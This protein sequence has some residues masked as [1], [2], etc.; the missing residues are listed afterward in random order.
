MQQVEV[1]E[2]NLDDWNA[3]GFPHLCDQ[4]FKQGA[5]DVSLAPIQMKK[6]RPGYTLCV[7]SPIPIGSELRN[8]IFT[9]T[10]SIGLRY[11]KEF[12]HTLPRKIIEVST[13]WGKLRAKLVVTPDGER[14]YPEYDE[15]RQAAVNFGVPLMRVYNAVSKMSGEQ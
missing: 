13:P 9:E 6:G 12:R 8:T 2:T 1:I 3:E 14:V 5:L 10:S 11:R 15:C 4:L 7:I